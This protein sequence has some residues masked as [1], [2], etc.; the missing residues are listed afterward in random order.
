MALSKIHKLQSLNTTFTLED[1]IMNLDYNIDTQT[2][3]FI[4]SNTI[5]NNNYSTNFEDVLNAFDSQ[6]AANYLINMEEIVSSSTE[7]DLVH[8]ELRSILSDAQINISAYDY[9]ILSIYA[10]TSM[11]SVSY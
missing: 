4:Y 6:D 3:E 8:T 2:K 1:C 7:E 9:Q 10:H 11:A 5:A